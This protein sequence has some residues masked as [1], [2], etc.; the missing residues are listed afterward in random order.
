[1]AA[2]FPEKVPQDDKAEEFSILMTPLQRLHSIC[3]IVSVV[4]KSQRLRSSEKK[5]R[6]SHLVGECHSGMGDTAVVTADKWNLL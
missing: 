6:P 2:G 1:M 3:F 4:P 5:H